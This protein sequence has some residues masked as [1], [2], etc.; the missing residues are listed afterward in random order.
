MPSVTYNAQSFA[1]DGRRIWLLGASIQYSH[2]PCQLWSTR[3]AAAKQA[4]YNTIETAC[5]WTIHEP[6]RGRYIFDG[7]ANLR[8]F[9]ETCAAAGMRVVLRAGP[10]IGENF[11]GGG[12]PGWLIET[13]GIVL[14]QANEIFLEHVSRYFRRLLGEIADLQATSGGPILLIQSEHAWTCSN[15]LQAERYLNEITRFIRESGITIPITNANDLWQESPGTID[16]WRGYDDLLV[17]LRQLRSVQPSAPRI[18]SAFEVAD[19]DV[20]GGPGDHNTK[21]APAVLRRLAE[22]LA[23][24]AQ[25]IVSPFHAGTNFDFLAGR[26]A[27]GPGNFVA[28]SA[29]NDPPLQESGARSEKYH[30]IR[31]LITFAN[32][33]SHVFAELDPDYHPIVFD[34]AAIEPDSTTRSSSSRAHRAGGMSVVPLRGAQG[35]MVFVFA[36]ESDSPTTTTLVLDDGI[37]LPVDLGRQ[38]VG[39]YALDVDLQGSGRLDF[40]NI[41]PWGVVNRNIVVFQGPPG[42]SAYLSISGTPLEAIV[43]QEGGEPLV[44]DHKGITVVICNHTQIDAAYHDDSAL[45]IGID[46]FDAGGAPQPLHGFPH[47]WV[48]RKNAQLEPLSFHHAGSDES[49]AGGRGRSGSGSKQRP[50]RHP[51]THKQ[52]PLPHLSW[53]VAP[54]TDY[55]TSQSPRFASL[56]GPETLSE[57]GAPSGYGWYRLAI[58]AAG[59]KLCHIPHSADRL[60]LFL[61]GRLQRLYG[62]GP[63]A[64]PSAFELKLAGSSQP[65]V[66]LVD[67]FG[68]FSEGNDLAQRKGIYGH[69][70]EVKALRS[71]KPKIATAT[72]VDPFILRGFVAGRAAG[73]MTDSQQAVWTISHSKKTPIIADIDGAAASAVVV[74]NDV[75]VAYYAGSTGACLDRIVLDP[76]ALDS[77][78]RGKNII[79]LAPDVRRAGAAAE[80]A[81]ATTL[82][83][84]VDALSQSASWAFAKWDVPSPSAYS[85]IERAQFRSLKGLPCW[86]RATF[87]LPPAANQSPKSKVQNPKEPKSAQKTTPPSQHFDDLDSLYLDTTG[88]SKGQVFINGRNLGRYFTATASNKPVGPQTRLYVPSPWLRHGDEPNELVIFEEHGFDPSRTRLLREA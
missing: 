62:V 3:I 54:L 19:A 80:L 74:L 48:V 66:A 53:Q 65:L 34:P 67:N 22:I 41:C 32:H 79:R 43:P 88:L 59:R 42:A 27:G 23:S 72:P 24:G 4:G 39:W 15:D 29:A 81:S 1:I 20:W 8:Q 51:S 58:N 50:A 84:C 55:I 69:L 38:P 77:F 83:E 47:P 73:Q 63:G 57:C 16:T 13:P 2:V 76:E 60:H 17:H 33:F 56:E 25:P 75:P 68:R 11:D 9:I 18:V 71:V 12:L 36:G 35:R 26:R 30:A 85:A 37:R 7:D 10:Y 31:R 14:R 49:A 40:S 61:D 28:T 70:Y 6:R 87:E 45:Y 21:P 5:P 82:Y 46:G 52:H 86:W 64:D 78:K 44:L